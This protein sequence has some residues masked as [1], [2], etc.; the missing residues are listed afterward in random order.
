MVDKIDDSIIKEMNKKRDLLFE[1]L[2]RESDRGV[3]LIGAA[4]INDA[5][6]TLIRAKFQEKRRKIKGMIKDFFGPMGPLGSFWAKIRLV[7][8]LELIKADEYHDLELLRKIRNRFAHQLEAVGFGDPEVIKL[9]ERLVAPERWA[10]H[11]FEK[12]QKGP[13]AS[14]KSQDTTGSIDE[15]TLARWRIYASI[16]CTIANLNVREVV[17]ETCP[18]ADAQKL[19]ETLTSEE[20]S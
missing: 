12:Q 4:F 20:S 3:I 5:L 11:E 2:A 15:G 18:A 6:E 1:A 8:G 16:V 13:T 19:L 14:S 7:Y 10:K 17:L 9:A